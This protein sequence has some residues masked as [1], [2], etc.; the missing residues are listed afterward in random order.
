MEFH[1]FSFP[2][3][4]VFENGL[5]FWIV[6][7]NNRPEVE[8]EGLPLGE[9]EDTNFFRCFSKWRLRKYMV[10]GRNWRGGPKIRS[11]LSKNEKI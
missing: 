2:I 8:W 6:I 1:I 10:Y 4:T 11:K 9:M 3:R 5:Q 7:F